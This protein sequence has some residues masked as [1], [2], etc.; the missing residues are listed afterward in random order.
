MKGGRVGVL[1]KL[2]L[3]DMGDMNTNSPLSLLLTLLMSSN[4]WRPH[5]HY[6]WLASLLSLSLNCTN[7]HQWLSLLVTLHYCPLMTVTGGPNLEEHH[8]Q[9]RVRHQ[10][11]DC[12]VLY[13]TLLYCTVLYFTVLYWTVL[14][15]TV[16]DCIVSNTR[17]LQATSQPNMLVRRRRRRRIYLRGHT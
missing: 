16:L 11:L 12:N 2:I 1:Q 13:C 3:T 9:D 4:D 8:G 6:C 15:C 14:Y 5:Y 7:V 17:V 10:V